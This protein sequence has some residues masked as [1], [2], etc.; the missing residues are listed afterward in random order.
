AAAALTTE[1]DHVGFVGGVETPLI[2]K[3][4]AGFVAGVEHLDD[5]VDIEIDYLSQPPDM[6]G[7][8]DPAQ[9]REAAQAQYDRGADVIYH[10]AGASG[11][12]ILQAAVD[13]DFTFSGVVSDRHEYADEEQ[14]P[15]D[16]TSALKEV[17]V[18]VFDRL[19]SVI[20]AASQPHLQR[21]DLTY[22]GA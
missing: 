4:E 5:D 19:N 13:N 11:N 2:N 10:A 18:S 9:G 7:F 6:N 3:F 16:L 20:E 8:S 12:G 14:Q 15:Y 1:E 17:H 21:S 22:R